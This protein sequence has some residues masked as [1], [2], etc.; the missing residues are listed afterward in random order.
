[1]AIEQI[2]TIIYMYVYNGIIAISKAD[3][4]QFSEKKDIN[5]QKRKINM[6]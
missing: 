1:M 6:E 5:F 4:V 2:K 3:I